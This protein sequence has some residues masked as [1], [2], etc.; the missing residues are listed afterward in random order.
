MKQKYYPPI[1][2]NMYSEEIIKELISESHSES[3]NNLMYSDDTVIITANT[4]NVNEGWI[5]RPTFNEPD[6]CTKDRNL[7]FPFSYY[8]KEIKTLRA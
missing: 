3:I 7:Y 6:L 8:G 4:K 5:A 2:F 1:L